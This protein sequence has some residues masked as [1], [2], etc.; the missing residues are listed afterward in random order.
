MH[1]RRKHQLKIPKLR[2]Q[3]SRNCCVVRLDGKDHYGPKWNASDDDF[4]IIKDDKILLHTV[5]TGIKTK[6]T[7][8]DEEFDQ[9]KA[10]ILQPQPDSN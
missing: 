3:K 7:A 9:L 10:S 8:N 5:I 1:A 4:K 6:T 2:H